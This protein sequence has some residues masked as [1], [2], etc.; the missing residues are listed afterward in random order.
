MV[1]VGAM[2]EEPHTKVHDKGEVEVEKPGTIEEEKEIVEIRGLSKYLQVLNLDK[3]HEIITRSA[4][5]IRRYKSDPMTWLQ[6]FASEFSQH[7]GV[8][9]RT[10]H[11]YVYICNADL[12]GNA[13]HQHGMICD[14][15]EVLWDIIST[16]SNPLVDAI[17]SVGAT[18][19][20]TPDLYGEWNII[21][22]LCALGLRTALDGRRSHHQKAFT[23]GLPTLKEIASRQ[24]Y[25]QT[26]IKCTGQ[27]LIEHIDN[28]IIPSDPSP[29][30]I[31]L[32]EL[33][34]VDDLVTIDESNK[35]QAR[36]QFMITINLPKAFH[37]Q[38]P[39]W[40][41]SVEE[42]KTICNI[43]CDVCKTELADA[44]NRVTYILIRKD[45]HPL[46]RTFLHISVDL[47][48]TANNNRYHAVKKNIQHKLCKLFDIL[49]LESRTP[50]NTIYFSTFK[51][52]G[53]A[54][55]AFFGYI[56]GCS[57]VHA[58]QEDEYLSHN[59]FYWNNSKDEAGFESL[60][61]FP[62]LK[63]FLKAGH[64][65]YPKLALPGESS[66]SFAAR[67][68]H[69]VKQ[70]NYYFDRDTLQVY[71]LK[72]G[73]TLEG[74]TPNSLNNIVNTMN[75]PQFLT[76]LIFRHKCVV[77]DE[78][79]RK[80]LDR[81][82][83]LYT[84]EQ[85]IF[86]DPHVIEFIDGYFDL[87]QKRVWKKDAII[88]DEL[89][90]CT[91]V[92]FPFKFINVTINLPDPQ[93]VMLRKQLH[94]CAYA[95]HMIDFLADPKKQMRIKVDDPSLLAVFSDISRKLSYDVHGINSV[96]W[97]DSDDTE[98]T[99]DEIKNGC[100]HIC[101]SNGVKKQ[102]NQHMQTVHCIS[103][104]NMEII[105][106]G[107]SNANM[108]H[109]IPCNES[110]IIGWKDKIPFPIEPTLEAIGNYIQTLPKEDRDLFHKRFISK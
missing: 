94:E 45:K 30:W 2:A 107:A 32:E 46:E 17:Q 74:T 19:L 71:Q 31:P 22:Q 18:I 105:T 83:D 68:E 49:V 50:Q 9:D 35:K 3:I 61:E 104:P 4:E 77:D 12:K 52:E 53:N 85:R 65:F 59:V 60:R 1:G 101:S 38:H 67:V 103:T 14:H 96:V 23:S 99:L 6:S 20:H 89:F 41:P 63:Y 79:A 11:K 75:F 110:T 81:M 5:R 55:F 47:E 51:N 7:V 15:G 33:I 97:N 92:T 54:T 58:I 98:M 34:D 70:N 29:D 84:T 21:L 42:L 56:Y 82:Q 90:P 13:T 108:A 78:H 69:V 106:E 44:K 37:K 72:Q 109:I 25:L 91:G 80:Y 10:R 36:S 43:I 100:L 16:H 24:Q 87:V 28:Q 95:D 48:K 8:T 39:G 76:K 64:N 62:K 88:N 93:D 57:H 86:M 40:D 66:K 27:P 26:R 73:I 102:K